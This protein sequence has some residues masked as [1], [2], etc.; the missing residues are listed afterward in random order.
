MEALKVEKVRKTFQKGTF[1]IHGVSFTVPSGVSAGLL[2]PN[3]AGKSTL[4]AI[5]AGALHPE[6]GTVRVYG[7]DVLA[8]EPEALYALGYVPQ[9]NGLDLYLSGYRNLQFQAHLYRL[10]AR[11]ARERIQELADGL[12]LETHLGKLVWTYSGGLRRRLALAMALLHRPRILVLDEPTAGLDPEV[13]AELWELLRALQR[14]WALTVLLST[15]Y[16]EEAD[17]LC[18]HVFF[19]HQGRIVL[20][21]A[22]DR[23]KQALGTSVVTIRGGITVRFGED[24]I[25]DLGRALGDARGFYSTSRLVKF[26]IDGPQAPDLGAAQRVLAR[27]GV[28]QTSLSIA[29]PTLEDVYLAAVQQDTASSQMA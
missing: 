16:L 6:E 4:M 12:G 23:L 8:R 28:S 10:P 2:G 11:V 26:A 14:D 7:H 29:P 13:R 24:L 27:Y 18:Q 19:L 3:G 1:G 5:V 20:Q 9:A 25:A 22:P 21:G 15:H 17:L